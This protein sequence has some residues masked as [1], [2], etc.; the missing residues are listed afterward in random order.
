MANSN[1]TNMLNGHLSYDVSEPGDPVEPTKTK[2]VLPPKGYKPLSI[3]QRNDWND[4][5]DYLEKQGVGGSKDLDN[6]DTSLGLS[7]FNKYL[8]ANPNSSITPDIIPSVQYEQQQL[9]RGNSFPTISDDTVF[10]QYQGQLSPQYRERPISDVDSWLGSLTS[11]EYYP[12][13]QRVLT[14]GGTNTRYDFGVNFE[15]AIKA[16][17]DQQ[18]ANQYIVK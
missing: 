7:H 2:A 14:K 15:D 13:A 6:R 12:R 18:I 11:R 4:F 17:N 10:K 9:R 16:L 5:L 3:Q 1:L 8:K